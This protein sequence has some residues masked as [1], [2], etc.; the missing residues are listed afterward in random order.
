MTLVGNVKPAAVT[1]EIVASTRP[2]NQLNSASSS[3]GTESAP[4]YTV[5]TLHSKLNGQSWQ[6]RLRYVQ[7]AN[8]RPFTY[9]QNDKPGQIMR[10]QF[11]DNTAFTELIL[12]NEMC[13]LYDKR[14]TTPGLE[15]IIRNA[16]VRISPSHLRGWPESLLGTYDIMLSSSSSV[17]L[18]SDAP[19]ITVPSQAV[20]VNNSMQLQPIQPP[21]P[22]PPSTQQ[23]STAVEIP[24]AGQHVTKFVPLNQVLFKPVDSKVDVLCLVNQVFEL[25]NIK[26]VGKEPLSLRNVT[27]VDKSKTV[28]QIAVWGAQAANFRFPRGTVLLLKDIFVSK[29]NGVSLS[30]R[31]STGIIEMKAGYLPQVDHLLDWYE[32]EWSKLEATTTT[33]E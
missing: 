24:A 21:P 22:I 16:S 4:S 9:R 8:I 30:V 20:V 32:N 27:I 11:H 13:D 17:M 26:R 7:K 5:N 25:T 15:Y 19:Q 29:Y 23:T 28:M 14:F 6:I 2:D 1:A 31:M 3:L 33:V 12:F 18:A 10:V